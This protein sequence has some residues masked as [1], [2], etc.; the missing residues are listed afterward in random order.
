[1][2][3][4][5]PSLLIEPGVAFKRYDP[6][7]KKYEL[8]W[9]ICDVNHK[10]EALPRR[11]ELTNVDLA[12][13][14]QNGAELVAV[15]RVCYWSSHK[16]ILSHYLE[17]INNEKYE[18]EAEGNA[19]GKEFAKLC[20]NAFYGSCLKQRHDTEIRTFRYGNE[21]AIDEFLEGTK[22]HKITLNKNASITIKGQSTK[23]GSKKSSRSTHIGAFV[24]SYSHL[25][26]NRSVAAAYGNLLVPKTWDDMRRALRT[27][28]LYGDTDS[29]YFHRSH[30]LNLMRY[31]SE[32]PSQRIL[33]DEVK[34]GNN[35]A[36]LGKFA[37]ECEPDD[38][39]YTPD[40]KKGHYVRIVKFASNAPKTYTHEA[41]VPLKDGTEWKTVY[42]S[43]CKGVPGAS[44]TAVIEAIGDKPVPAGFEKPIPFN[45]K[46]KELHE[47]MSLAVKSKEY[48]LRTFSSAQLKLMGAFT[49]EADQYVDSHS[50]VR[51]LEP[52]SISA[53]PMQRNVCSDG[54][55]LKWHGRRNLT[56]AEAFHL[57]F[58][59]EETRNILVPIGF[60][61]DGALFKLGAPT[62]DP[63]FDSD[64]EL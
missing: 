62:P 1:V 26:L 47:Y 54:D 36:K 37:D 14:L 19:G 22:N 6:T 20:A 50:T 45:G 21:K 38:R 57:D 51:Q 52:Y 11:Q 16:K 32:H 61:Y 49:K 46:S 12:I 10:G 48:R 25:D 55:D 18:A 41:E 17:E 27:Q 58:T 30:V 8:L 56:P 9:G 31:D 34:E 23:N 64:W 24:L 42:G 59:P 7:G 53:T 3:L 39:D 28:I 15:Y 43:K 33:Y 40:Y 13:A 4:K 44:A 29:L 63:F 2:E 35:R 5:F 60:N